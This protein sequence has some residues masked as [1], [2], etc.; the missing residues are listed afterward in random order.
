MVIFTGFT[1]KNTHFDEKRHIII[2]TKHSTTDIY[3]RY[4]SLLILHLKYQLDEL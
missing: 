4:S 2:N 3:H 1:I